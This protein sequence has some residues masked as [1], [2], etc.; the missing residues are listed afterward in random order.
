M[1]EE[2]L[3]MLSRTTAKV[4]G[5]VENLYIVGAFNSEDQISDQV[6]NL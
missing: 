5:G 4:F 2:M 3:I 6:K 1:I